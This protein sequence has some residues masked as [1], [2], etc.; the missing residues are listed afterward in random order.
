[1]KVPDI[2]DFH[3]VPVIEI[4]VKPGDAV[5]AEQPLLTLESDKASMDVPSP[6]DGTVR[7]LKVKVGDKVSQ[8]TLI[9][10][11]DAQGAAAPAKSGSRRR[12]V[13]APGSRASLPPN[14]RRPRRAASPRCP[15][16][17]GV[18]AGPS[19]RRLARELGVDLTQ[20]KGTGEKG[21][22]TKDDLK[23]VAW[24]GARPPRSKGG[25]ALPEVPA[26]DFAK[27][28]PIETKPLSRI[29]KDFR[30][31]PARLVG[32]HSPCDPYRRGRHH[33]AGGVPQVARRRRQGRQEGALSRFLV[34]AADEGERGDTEGVPDIQSA[35]SPAK[36]ALILRLYW[37]IGVAVD[38]PDGLWSPW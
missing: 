12:E 26:V 36:D 21:R 34:A 29:Q 7:E 37:N 32:Q 24:A 1:M 19:V 30:A 35:L 22:I 6:A 8:G 28:G 11:F 14:P 33:G 20:I 3:D 25:A 38:T 27:F 23:G 9:L 10:T 17:H 16:S 18:F 2:G 31:A 15:I 4:L 5:K 13:R